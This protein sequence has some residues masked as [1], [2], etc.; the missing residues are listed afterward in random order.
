MSVNSDTLMPA[1]AKI[2]SDRQRLFLLY[3][4]G[5]LVD[6]VVLGCQAGVDRFAQFVEF[7]PRIGFPQIVFEQGQQLVGD[8][9]V[10]HGAVE[11]AQLVADV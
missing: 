4:V 11:C 3:F 10:L 1:A 7:K 6:L 5:A 2:Y 9:F 8:A